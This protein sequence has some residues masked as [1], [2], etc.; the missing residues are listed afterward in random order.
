MRHQALLV[1]EVV[2]H[3]FTH[4]NEIGEPSYAER[5]LSRQTLADPST[6]QQS[7][8]RGIEPLSELERS[9]SI[10]N[11]C[12]VRTMSVSSDDDFHLLYSFPYDTCVFP[13]LLSLSWVI[14]FTR[15]LR[16]FL[17][18][19]LRSCYIA[20]VQPDLARHSIGTRCPALE[21]LDIELRS[22]RL[23][24]T[25]CSINP[26]NVSLFEAMSSWPQ[27]RSLSLS[28]PHHRPPQ[29]TFREL[30]AAL[31]QCPHLHALHVEI[32]VVNI[33]IKLK[34]ESFQHT[35][36]ESISYYSS[37]AANAE[38]VARIIFTMLPNVQLADTWGDVNTHL[39]SLRASSS[40]Q[41]AGGG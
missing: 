9:Q 26:D 5:P 14:I 15:Y 1:P 33:D 39:K 24:V 12:C 20:I 32:D 28:D 41:G 36:L 13:K 25:S 16:F 17:S 34:T 6:T 4:V 22:L 7:W 37:P 11:S 3:I 8:S 23:Y 35:S 2:L 10:R 40:L 30:F 19:T 21:G 29:V 31:S 27:I 38:A 18:P